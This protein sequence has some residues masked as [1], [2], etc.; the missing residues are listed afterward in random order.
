MNIRGTDSTAPA[1]AN[2]LFAVTAPALDTPMNDFSR[3]LQVPTRHEDLQS[4]RRF[5]PADQPDLPAAHG[6][7]N[8]TAKSRSEQESR[9]QTA[10]DSS[11]TSSSETPAKGDDSEEQDIAAESLAAVAQAPAV[12]STSELEKKAVAVEELNIVIASAV[13]DPAANAGQQTVPANE[14]VQACEIPAVE[15][16]VAQLQQ[17]AVAEAVVAVE[18][19]PD[20]TET[21]LESPKKEAPKSILPAQ[22]APADKAADSSVVAAHANGEAAARNSSTKNSVALGDVIPP[23]KPRDEPAATQ[24]SEANNSTKPT[25]NFGPH[26]LHLPSDAPASAA[27]PAEPSGAPAPAALAPVDGLSTRHVDQVN[28]PITHS[29]T[30]G[31]AAILNRLPAHALGQ[32]PVAGQAAGP[33][34]AAVDA[35]RFLQRVVGAFESARDRGG[36]IRLRLSPP[37]LGVLRVEVTMHE[38][39]LVARV[40]AETPDARAILLENLPALRERLAEQGLRLE[41]FDVDL[42]Q[43]EPNQQ[44]RDFPDQSQQRPQPIEGRPARPSSTRPLTPEPPRPPGPTPITDWQNRRLN[45][46]V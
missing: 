8:A 26:P 23:E 43:Q 14:T 35:A 30:I 19:V 31:S 1:A 11:A 25:A 20:E 34:P 42:L 44:G 46:I 38:L 22:E 9:D 32:R 17:P 6:N 28:P 12:L 10:E 45:V 29:G 7:A 27:T 37:E 24:N 5:E 40:S 41:R 2:D 21:K 4:P 13:I 39:G 15:E 18:A 16:A 33:A 3:A 36:E